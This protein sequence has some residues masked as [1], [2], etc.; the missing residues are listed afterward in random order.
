[1]SLSS[2]QCIGWGLLALAFII[3][4]GSQFWNKSSS[5]KQFFKT[6]PPTVQCDYSPE[7]PETCLN[8]IGAKDSCI[9]CSVNNEHIRLTNGELNK[10]LSYNSPF[11]TYPIQ[12]I[13]KHGEF[14]NIVR[15]NDIKC[16]YDQEE[17]V[18]GE[19]VVPCVINNIL[20]AYLPTSFLT[21]HINRALV[22]GILPLDAIPYKKETK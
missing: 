2:V 14:I 12:F 4:I 17:I 8:G 3:L 19:S 10:Y 5:R 15:Y 16:N 13:N 7:A 20:D 11:G 9:S 1:M 18:N 6:F 21:D 22:L